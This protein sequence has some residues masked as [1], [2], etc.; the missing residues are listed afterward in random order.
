MHLLLGP[1]ADDFARVQLAESIFEAIV[2]LDVFIPVLKFIQRC[3]ENLENALLWND[4]VLKSAEDENKPHTQRYLTDV[5]QPY[6]LEWSCETHLPP[7]A[8]NTTDSFPVLIQPLMFSSIPEFTILYMSS[9]VL[10]STACSCQTQ[11][12]SQ[13]WLKLNN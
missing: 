13:H 2:I 5:R 10:G 11:H 8:W 6:E 4:L 7:L 9:L 12:R 1:K 3:L